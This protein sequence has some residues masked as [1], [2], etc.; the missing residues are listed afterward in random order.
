MSRD[1]QRV[2][3]RSPKEVNTPL[4]NDLQP[5]I[6]KIALGIVTIGANHIS[7]PIPGKGEIV[8][9]ERSK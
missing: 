9:V 1:F 3:I 2:P 6:K 5:I 7:K 8:W 4:L